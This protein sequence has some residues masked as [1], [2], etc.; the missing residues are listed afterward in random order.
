MV[1]KRLINTFYLKF[2]FSN[3]IKGFIHKKHT[4]NRPL[5]IDGVI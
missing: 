2:I 5:M 3:P 1:I 4:K